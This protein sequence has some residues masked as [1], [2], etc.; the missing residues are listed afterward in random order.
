MS[1]NAKNALVIYQSEIG[2]DE[3]T[4]EW[5]EVTQDQINQ[6]ADLTKD[7]QFIH[8]NP[9]MAAMTP[10]GGTIAHGFLTLSMLT[11]L[12][13]G[14]GLKTAGPEKYEGLMMGLNYG[15]NRV[16]FV[17]PV[18]SGARIRA[19]VVTAN[20]KLKGNSIEVT[21]SITVE[22]EDEANR[23]QYLLGI[24]IVA[25]RV[26]DRP[27]RLHPERRLKVGFRRFEIAQHQDGRPL[28]HGNAGGQLAA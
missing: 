14:T 17:N 10:F 7:H 8:V 6:F 5:F 11:H 19:R 27:R 26:F 1:D 16:R 25:F 2:T 13:M 28:R 22:I 3:A 21:R 15:F 20:A 23:L 12:V 4:G 24:R 18:R 9:E